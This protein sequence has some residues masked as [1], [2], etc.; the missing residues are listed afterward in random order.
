[1]KATSKFIEE[2]VS[3]FNE[4]CFGGALPQI[5]IV[6]T[7]A[8]SFLGKLTYKGRRSLFG[9]FGKTDFTLRISSLYDLPER[10]WEDVVIHELIHY[11]IGVRGIRD[12]SPHGRAFRRMMDDINSRYGRNVTVHHHAVAGELPEKKVVP[13]YNI[14]CASRF[15]DGNWGVTVC[16]PSRVHDLNRALPRYYRLSEMAWYGSW[17]PFFNGFPRSR[18]PK[19][20]KVSKEDLDAH[21]TGAQRLEWRNRELAPESAQ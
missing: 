11:Y 9:L 18:T 20:Y 5:P 6:L 2:K 12:T 10:E 7:N 15:Q 16:L 4:L 21:L 14:L 19:I 13:R 3:Q 8:R 1:M 17:D